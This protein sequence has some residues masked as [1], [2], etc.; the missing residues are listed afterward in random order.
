VTEVEWRR[1]TEGGHGGLAKNG[2]E[3]RGEVSS[4]TWSGGEYVEQQGLKGKNS[5]YVL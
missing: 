3:Q 2:R 1:V 5:H 4:T